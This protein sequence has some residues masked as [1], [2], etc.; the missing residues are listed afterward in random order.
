MEAHVELDRPADRIVDRPR[1]VD[2]PGAAALLCVSEA[3][4]RR[5]LTRKT[6]KRYKVGKGP[7]TRTLLNRDEVLSLIREA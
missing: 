4:I 2:I 1:F 5:Y 6:L 3:T 7:N